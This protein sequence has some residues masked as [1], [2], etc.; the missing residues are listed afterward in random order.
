MKIHIKM[1]NFLRLPA[2]VILLSI[3]D[4]VGGAFDDVTHRE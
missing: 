1:L 2:I 3:A 4:L